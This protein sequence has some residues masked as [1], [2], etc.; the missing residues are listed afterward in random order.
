MLCAD[1]TALQATIDRYITQYMERQTMAVAGSATTAYKCRIED[2]RLTTE[3]TTTLRSE[4]ARV[5]DAQEQ[6]NAGNQVTV[7]ASDMEAL[8]QRLASWGVR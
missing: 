2:D 4:C 3:P 8:R 7:A 1:T 5:A 6:L